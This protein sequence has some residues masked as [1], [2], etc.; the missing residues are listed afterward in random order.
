MAGRFVVS[1]QAKVL[2][3]IRFAQLKEPPTV[4]ILA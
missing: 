2:L 1:E 3:I 4:A